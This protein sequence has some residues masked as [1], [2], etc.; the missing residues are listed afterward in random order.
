MTERLPF[1]R[2]RY[3]NALGAWLF[4]AWSRAQWLK[5]YRPLFV[6][7]DEEGNAKSTAFN[8]H[9]RRHGAA[10]KILT[11]TWDERRIVREFTHEFTPLRPVPAVELPYL[12]RDAKETAILFA[13][14]CAQVDEWAR[15]S[16]EYDTYDRLA[17]PDPKRMYA[18]LRTLRREDD[19]KCGPDCLGCWEDFRSGEH[20]LHITPAEERWE[21]V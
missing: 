9:D 10:L 7:L 2:E 17:T 3:T 4:E 8:W 18:P 15:Q 21:R 14:V 1:T 12:L 13:Q 5:H 6:E 19:H 16:G 20:F 11:G